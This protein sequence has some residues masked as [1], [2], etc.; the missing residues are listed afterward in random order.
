MPLELEAQEAM[1][2]TWQVQVALL[3]IV[4]AVTLA[5]VAMQIKP[6]ALE[7]LRPELELTLKKKINSEGETAATFVVSIFFQKTNT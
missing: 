5:L 4:L 3:L 2:I 6:L 7:A 1:L